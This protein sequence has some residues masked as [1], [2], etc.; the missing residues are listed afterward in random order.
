MHSWMPA[1]LWSGHK[2]CMSWERDVSARP[3]GQPG[4]LSSD[5]ACCCAL[6]EACP[7]AHPVRRAQLDTG[8]M[9]ERQR[10]MDE[11]EEWYKGKAEW[12][13]WAKA[14][15]AAE[16]LGERAWRSGPFYR[17]GGGGRG[18]PR[19]ACRGGAQGVGRLQP[20]YPQAQWLA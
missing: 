1:D 17:G 15:G 3:S 13:A 16:L 5:E 6:L 9:A 8:I 14:E 10:L 18:D 20:P 7:T 12:L 19:Q 4:C 11:W 2:L